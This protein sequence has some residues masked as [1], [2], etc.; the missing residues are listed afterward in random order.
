MLDLVPLARPGRKVTDRDV[1]SELIGQ[2]LKLDLPKSQSGAVAAT[3]IS[4]DQEP[5]SAV[6]ERAS[7]VPPPATDTLHG[8]ARGIVVDPDADPAAIVGE[9]EIGR[10]S[11]RERV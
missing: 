7:H 9:I 4:C 11:C 1:H 8:K 5:P 10:A 3:A 2:L 6:V